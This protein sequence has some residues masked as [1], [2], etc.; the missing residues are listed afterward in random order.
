M[1]VDRRKL[2]REAA[3]DRLATPARL[4]ELMHVTSPKGWLNLL[5]C[6]LVIATAAVWAIYGRVPTVV[7]G[8][9]ILIK[10]GS[11]QTIEAPASGQIFE[12]LV[13]VGDQVRQDQVIGRLIDPADGNRAIVVTSPHFGRILETRVIKGNVVQAGAGLLSLEIPGKSLEA[14]LYLPPIDAKKV[15]PGMEVQLSLA[16]VKREEYGMMLGRVM[17]VGQFPA[18]AAAMR[19]VLGSDEFVKAMSANGA[20]VEVRVELLRSTTTI[21]GYR[22]TSTMGSTF[23]WLSSVAGAWITAESLA[24][25]P[26]SM[27]AW[28]PGAGVAPGPPVSIESGTPIHAAITLEEQPPIYLVLAKLNRPTRRP[29]SE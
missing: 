13:N 27:V 8:Q 5:A 7:T 24:W 3:L 14:I 22:W 11:L 9:G 28:L 29:E 20:P 12:I 10:D 23:E 15:S 17:T 4:D 18:S 6:W 1:A 21:S 25:M 2:F 19:R 26:T 16:S